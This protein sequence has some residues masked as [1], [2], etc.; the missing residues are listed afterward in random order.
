MIDK[1]T[2]RPADSVYEDLKHHGVEDMK[3]VITSK[4]TYI[5]PFVNAEAPYLVIEDNFP[6]DVLHWKKQVFISQ[7]EKP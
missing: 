3:P 2:P 4:K 6:M 5:A 1:I 7:T